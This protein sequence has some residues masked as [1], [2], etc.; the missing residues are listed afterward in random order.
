[1]KKPTF[2]FTS[3]NV[4]FLASTR[5]LEPDLSDSLAQS[6]H[7]RYSFEILSIGIAI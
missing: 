5:I 3:V 4:F 2:A 7:R 1:M 6:R